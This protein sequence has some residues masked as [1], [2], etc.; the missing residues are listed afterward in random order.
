MSTQLAGNTVA[1]DTLAAVLRERLRA[2]GATAHLVVAGDATELSTETGRK[3]LDDG[4]AEAAKGAKVTVE[5]L[6]RMSFGAEVRF[7]K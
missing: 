5:I 2:K 4:I 1:V 7:T 6:A 3:A